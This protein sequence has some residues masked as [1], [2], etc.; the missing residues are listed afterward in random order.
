MK[1]SPNML[2]TDAKPLHC[3]KFNQSLIEAKPL[4]GGAEEKTERR[5]SDGRRDA[6][7]RSTRHGLAVDFPPPLNAAALHPLTALMF[8][9][10]R[11]VG[12]FI[13]KPNKT[14]SDCAHPPTSTE[15]TAERGLG[16][17]RPGL[18]PGRD[19]F[20]TW[21]QPNYSRQL[22][23]SLPSRTTRLAADLVPAD[24]ATAA[25]LD[26]HLMV[27]LSSPDPLSG[28]IFFF[29]SPSPRSLK[30]FSLCCC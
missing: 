13:N 17:R 7:T 23:A 2:V 21:L 3:F 1:A 20:F 14:K 12:G 18:V 24:A 10:V 15:H 5:G 6:R 27:P 30:C 4:P 26:T 11:S 16:G 25:V 28:R 9:A 19:F 8:Q 22:E 29:F